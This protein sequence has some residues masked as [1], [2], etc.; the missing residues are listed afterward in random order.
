MKGVAIEV[1]AEVCEVVGEKFEL[2][3]WSSLP[4]EKGRGERGR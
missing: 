1:I 3:C 4:G 2:F